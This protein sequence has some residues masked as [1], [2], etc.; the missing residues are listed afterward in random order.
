MEYRKLGNSGL[1]VSAIGLGTN[2]FGR[3]VDQAGTSRVLD[4]ALEEGV[5]FID[6]ANIYG[7]GQSEE[8]IGKAIEE[9][10]DQYILATKTAMKVDNGPNGIGASRHHL[11][12]EVEKSLT[13]LR[14]DYIDLYQIH[15][16]DPNT[17]IEETMH[18]LDQ[19][20]AQG[21][22]RY[23]GCSNY[24]S[25]ELCEAIWTSRTRNL[26]PFVTLQPRYSML[27]RGIE[28][29]LVPFCKTY[30]IGIL[31]YFPLANGFLTGKYRR[32]EAAP[33]GTRL[34]ENDRGMFTDANF[35]ILEGL[36]AFAKE[37]GHTVLDLAFAWLLANPAVTSVI[38]GATKPG[39]VTS[40]AAT[41]GWLLSDEE[42]SEIDTILSGGD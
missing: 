30:G 35:D 36:E 12:R 6:T 37:R 13:R 31:P 7:S 38:A 3:R 25:W 20:V 39:Q 33:E 14:T 40:N 8:Y 16:A 22:V 2:N 4:Q 1:D 41:V 21:K 5:T 32:G 10:R 34:A 9:K 15:R 28:S 18:A 23:V 11:F 26:V 24:A 42:M 19:L 27:D 29:E 17:P